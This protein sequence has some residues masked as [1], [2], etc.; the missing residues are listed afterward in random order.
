MTLTQLCVFPTSVSLQYTAVCECIIQAAVSFV[1]CYL[2]GRRASSEPQSCCK[3]ITA[4]L[5]FSFAAA[6]RPH[7]DATVLRSKR[8]VAL[9]RST[10]PSLVR[11]GQRELEW[12]AA[13]SRVVLPTFI[14]KNNGRKVSKK[15][16]GHGLNCS[17]ANRH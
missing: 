16:K 1:F 6:E 4:E 11:L 2:L 13:T 8:S 9:R 3:C 5:N 10:T 12:S 15:K 7:P 17:V 14:R